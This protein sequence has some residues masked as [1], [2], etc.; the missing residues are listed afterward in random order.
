MDK[1]PWII[2]RNG[3]KFNYH[4]FSPDDFDINEICF[5]LCGL[6]RFTNKGSAWISLAQHCIIVSDLLINYYKRPDLAIYGLLHD[7]AEAYTNDFNSPLKSILYYKNKYGSISHISQLEDEILRCIAK[8]FGLD[9]FVLQMYNEIEDGRTV[10][11]ADL[12][13]GQLEA[14]Q[15]MGETFP[16]GNIPK[17]LNNFK[18]IPMGMDEAKIE[19]LNKFHELTNDR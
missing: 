19:F 4:D 18:I 8:K 14:R 13:C 12:L 6:P 5:T 11:S 2:L 16:V 7:A 17:E 3:K 9:E 10:K 1:S 15:Y